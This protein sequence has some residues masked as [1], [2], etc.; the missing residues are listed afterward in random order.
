MK[1]E[2]VGTK[3]AHLQNTTPGSPTA[4]DF[5]NINFRVR[6]YSFNITQHGTL[7]VSVFYVKGTKLGF[8]DG[9]FGLVGKEGCVR[10]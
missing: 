1:P 7:T 6:V 4:G 8:A 10:P 2:T 9:M 3:L 5:E